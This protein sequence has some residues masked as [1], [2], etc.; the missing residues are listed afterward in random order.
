MGAIADLSQ[1]INTAT[2]GTGAKEYTPFYID[3]RVGAGAGLTPVA[4]QYL[5]LWTLNRF[6]RGAGA[7]P[8]GTARNPDNTTQGALGQSDPTGGRQKYLAGGFV[9]GAPAQVVTWYDR[10]ADISGLSGTVTTAQNTTSLAVTRY[11]GTES[12]GNEIWI[13]IYTQIGASATGITANYTNQDGTSGRT[14]QT[15]VIGGTGRREQARIIRVPLANGDTGVR[16]VESVTVGIS[17]GTA[18]D[19]GV[20]IARPIINTNIGLSGSGSIID[21]LTQLG[22]FPEIETGACL[23]PILL[24]TTT[25]LTG[26]AGVLSF[27]E[28]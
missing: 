24:A 18:G 20:T 3:N 9:S 14:S 12:V 2:G 21:C 8:G 1:L 23:S 11:T 16:S 22:A 6:P 25:T 4:S 26:V 10:L 19:F 27:V 17:T 28:A 7:A 13:E 15:V 5:S